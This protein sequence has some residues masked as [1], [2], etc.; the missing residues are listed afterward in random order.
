MI[1]LCF[2]HNDENLLRGEDYLDVVDVS[3]LGRF[4]VSELN[5]IQTDKKGN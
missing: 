2:E 4:M 3:E 5:K 1:I